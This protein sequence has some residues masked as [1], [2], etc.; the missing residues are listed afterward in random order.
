MPTY[1]DEDAAFLHGP[2]SIMVASRDRGRVPSL[3]RAFAIQC[4]PDREHVSLWL[5][6]A[7]STRVLQELEPGSPIAVV[8]NRTATHFTLQ[9]KG[10]VTRVRP[11][12]AEE[13]P[14]L[15]ASFRAFVN[16]LI[17]VGHSSS[18]GAVGL[19]GTFVVVELRVEHLYEQTPGPGAGDRRSAQ[20]SS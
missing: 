19:T 15:Q 4:A 10:R 7:L 17:S 3:T 11:M 20:S 6:E 1:T 9:L 13:G 8:A 12:L 14:Y 18:L 16:E 5:P 2:L